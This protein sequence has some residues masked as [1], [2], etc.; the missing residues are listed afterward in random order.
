[1]RRALARGGAVRRPLARLA[2]PAYPNL[3]A[4]R[5]PGRQGDQAMVFFRVLRGLFAAVMA[6]WM[7]G[8]I[9]SFLSGLLLTLLPI[10]WGLPLPWSD[11]NDFAETPDGRVF[12]S[13]RFYNRALCY[14]RSGNFLAAH[15]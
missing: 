14:D 5:A 1:M 4:R 12:V 11:F 10:P 7:A 2:P 6:C 15:R 3:C 8:C 9:L 13:V